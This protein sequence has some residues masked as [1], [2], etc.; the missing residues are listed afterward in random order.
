MRKNSR[1]TNSTCKGLPRNQQR[2]KVSYSNAE[3][4]T[5]S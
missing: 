4:K 2:L 3:G 1:R 5:K